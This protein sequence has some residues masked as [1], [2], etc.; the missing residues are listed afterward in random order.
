VICFV[1]HSCIHCNNFPSDTP[2]LLSIRTCRTCNTDWCWVCREKGASHT[3][4]PKP[5]KVA[6]E[7]NPRERFALT[8]QAVSNVERCEQPHVTTEPF[9]MHRIRA[10]F[11]Q[12][13]FA[14]VASELYIPDLAALPP[15]ILRRRL[16]ANL[17]QV[18]PKTA[19]LFAE[20]LLELFP[21]AS[22]VE[23]L[24][25][26]FTSAVGRLRLLSTT[27]CSHDTT[28]ALA[29]PPLPVAPETPGDT[30]PEL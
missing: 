12:M 19:I 7:T 4:C 11:L 23:V 13:F 29:P 26:P 5:L 27:H 20:S 10:H 18:L 24:Q 8:S 25:L 28:A 3:K 9:I 2:P 6:A 21:I 1:Y 15:I 30:Q 14:D 16:I 17:M 22:L